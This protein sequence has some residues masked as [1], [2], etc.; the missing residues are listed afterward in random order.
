M[1]LQVLNE[2]LDPLRVLALKVQRLRQ[3]VVG[4]IYFAHLLVDLNRNSST[5]PSN[6]KTGASLGML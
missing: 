1:G 5:I 3:V 4:Y 2:S 6:V